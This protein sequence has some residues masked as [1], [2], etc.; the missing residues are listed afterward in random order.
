MVATS[1][2]LAALD[3]GH[4]MIDPGPPDGTLAASLTATRDEK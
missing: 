4:P 2:G 3:P 1:R